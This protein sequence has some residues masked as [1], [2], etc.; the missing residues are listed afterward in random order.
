MHKHVCFLQASINS[1][2][3]FISPYSQI[4]LI[5]RLGIC[6][7]RNS[8]KFLL[9]NESFAFCRSNLCVKSFSNFKNSVNLQSFKIKCA[10]FPWK[11]SISNAN[12]WSLHDASA[13]YIYTIH[14]EW[15][16]TNEFNLE[17]NCIKLL[18][19]VPMEIFQPNRIHIKC[20]MK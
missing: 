12:R 17:C 14:I 13:L 10:Y 9:L 8:R 3:I 20:C 7:L 11:T 1:M 19:I 16:K 5:K 6:Y 15:N 2:Q 18:N 4:W